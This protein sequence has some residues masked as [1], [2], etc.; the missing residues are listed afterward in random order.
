MFPINESLQIGIVLAVCYILFFFLYGRG[1]WRSY[2]QKLS[3]YAVLFPLGIASS[4]QTGT[5]LPLGIIG[6]LVICLPLGLL[7]KPTPG[8]EQRRVIPKTSAFPGYIIF[9]FLGRKVELLPYLP[10]IVVGIAVVERF[11]F[12]LWLR[13]RSA[14]V[15]Q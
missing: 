9:F 1:E 12:Y 3:H 8:V 14:S 7:I 15:A 13:K 10:W 11:V 6:L 5:Y 4:L 2:H